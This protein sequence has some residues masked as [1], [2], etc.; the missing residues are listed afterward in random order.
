MNPWAALIKSLSDTYG[1]W[2]ET[3]NSAYERKRDK[4]QEKAI[5]AGEAGFELMVEV[6]AFVAKHTKFNKNQKKV[7]DKLKAKVLRRKANFNKY[8]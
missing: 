4:N 8:D 7:F 3:R 5:K 2:L 1:K 6:F